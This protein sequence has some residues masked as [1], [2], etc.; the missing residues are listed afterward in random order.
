MAT[1]PRDTKDH[2]ANQIMQW[3]L[4]AT[5]VMMM[6]MMMKSLRSTTMAET[7]QAN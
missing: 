5:L 7:K 3:Q 6:M 2:Q 4:K 1:N